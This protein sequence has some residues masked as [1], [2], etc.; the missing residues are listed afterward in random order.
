MNDKEKPR[1]FPEHFNIGKYSGSPRDFTKGKISMPR[2]G[3]DP[4]ELWYSDKDFQKNVNDRIEI[5]QKQGWDTTRKF[6][7][8]TQSHLDLGWM[9]HFRQGVAKAER[10]FSKVHGH[11]QLFKPFTFTGSQ[12]ACYQWVKF[13]SPD[14]WKNVVQDVKDGRH[15]VQGGC[16]CEA[17]GRMPSGEA[18][19]RQRLYGQLFYARNFGKIGNVAW[20][21]DSFGYADNLPQIFSK[22]GSDGFMTSKLVSNKQTK[23]P[24]WA[25]LWEAP[26]GSR[27]LSYQSG[28][29]QKLGPLGGYDVRQSDSDVRESYIK[30]YRLLK[31]NTTLTITY[32]TDQPENHENVSDEEIPFLGCFFGE[33]DGGHGPQGVE[34]AF[35]RAF[36]ER[37][38]AEWASTHEIYSRLQ[39]Y[40]DRLPIWKDELYYEFHRGSLTSQTLMKRMNRFFEWRLLF[41]EGLYSIATS[42]TNKPLESFK[43]FYE[44]E[45]DQIRTTDNPIEQI[46]QNILLMQFHDVLP[47]SS[48]PEVYDEC[49]EFWHQDKFLLKRLEEDAMAGLVSA[50]NIHGLKPVKIHLEMEN[51]EI[52]MLP[53]FIMNATGGSGPQLIEI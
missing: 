42:I 34:M 51:L 35:Y 48:L 10:T 24:F 31:P 25:W 6:I 4:L 52:L 29:H 9:W 45:L 36:V 40:R 16:W 21:P 18:W 12:P 22:S 1:L 15:E 39:Q 50:L 5:L 20:F 17:D 32:E 27:L 23:W 28:I 11:F 37:G 13:N 49:Y 14:I 7:A 26:D 19:V 3:E 38:Y 53:A 30:S 47:G 8:T 33:G 43:H 44:D 41:I 46:W 2:G